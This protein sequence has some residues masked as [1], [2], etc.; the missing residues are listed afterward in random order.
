MKRP[1]KWAL[2]AAGAVLFAIVVNQIFPLVWY[3]PKIEASVSTPDGKPVA[4]AIVVVSWNIEGPWN[5]ASLGQMSVAE[6]VTD[7][8]GKFQIPAWGPR[9]NYRG[10]IPIDEPTVRIFKSGFAPLTIQNYE[11]VPM[12][13]A[14]RII[15]FRLQN[16]NIVLTPFSGTM[17]EYE[18][19]LH[20]FQDDLRKFDI[21]Q[22]DVENG[23]YWKQTPRLLLALEDVKL[24]MALQ[25][26]GQSLRLAYRIPPT[27]SAS[28]CG[29]EQEFF[30]DYV[31]HHQKP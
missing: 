29:S 26:G 31:N 19:S 8:N 16:Q 12:Q 20:Q 10:S 30:Q 14:S 25:G 11:D 4:G 3:S 2:G 5:G 21:V 13:A 28:P 9:F 7:A 1:L 24:K 18:I 23:C 22:S 27:S 17:A 6:T 15:V